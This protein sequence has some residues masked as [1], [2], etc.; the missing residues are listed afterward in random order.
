M[1][2]G[3]E[4]VPATDAEMLTALELALLEWRP[5]SVRDLDDLPHSLISAY[6]QIRAGQA[7]KSEPFAWYRT[8]ARGL[9][10]LSHLFRVGPDG[11]EELAR[12]G[13]A[14]TPGE[15]YRREDGGVKCQRCDAIATGSPLRVGT[16]GDLDEE[17]GA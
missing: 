11:P 12:C 4:Q 2:A 7:A 10:S 16:I 6:W 1:G 15:E 3:R 14:R 13:V 5:A 9:V 17:T 8:G